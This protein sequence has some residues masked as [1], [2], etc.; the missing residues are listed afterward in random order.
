[1]FT[2]RGIR[3]LRKSRRAASFGSAAQLAQKIVQPPLQF[4][5]AH[6]FLAVGFR[7]PLVEVRTDR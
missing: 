4:V 3:L 2:V 6:S 5:G 7:H 1:M